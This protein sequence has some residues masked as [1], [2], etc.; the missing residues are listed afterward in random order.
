MGELRDGVVERFIAEDLLGGV[1][2][3]VVAPDD[4]RDPHRDV[5]DD[6]AEVVGRRAV[7]PHEDPVVE[8]TVLERD[9]PV[10]EV[11]DHGRALGRNAQAQ[12]A[13]G[14][15]AVAA[16]SR[17]PERLLPLLRL[18]SLAIEQLRRAVA[19]VGAS[20]R[21]QTPGVLAIDREPLGL[22][23]ARRR[24]ALVPI[25][26]EPA[27]RVDDRDDVLVGRPRAVRVLDSKDE[28]AP[29][30][31]R[32]EPVEERGAG[33]ADVKMARRA[34]REPDAD[35]RGHVSISRRAG[36][37]ACRRKPGYARGRRSDTRAGRDRR[38]RRTAPRPRA[39]NA[40]AAA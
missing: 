5:V 23:I 3:M 15:P 27:E 7:G 30:M 38:S 14:Q 20:S 33:A 36:P 17:V 35:R 37:T 1:R 21:D 24:R 28:G 40:G 18:R 26:T 13:G 31:A 9:R 29:V 22:A 12:C 39:A 4:M 8:L 10:D 2:Q 25:E 19:V 6:D 34:R 16:A 32:E 11:V